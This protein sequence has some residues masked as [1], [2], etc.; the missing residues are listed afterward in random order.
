[1]PNVHTRLTQEY[2]ATPHIKANQNKS[3][4]NAYQEKLRSYPQYMAYKKEHDAIRRATPQ[5]KAY[6]KQYHKQYQNEYHEQRRST[7]QIN[8][9][10]R[11]RTVESY[12]RNVERKR[13]YNAEYRKR[14][15]QE[16]SARIV[17]WYARNVERKRAYNA[18]YRNRNVEREIA[19]SAEYRKRRSQNIEGHKTLMQAWE[20]AR[21]PS[22]SA[23][24]P[25]RSI[26]QGVALA[27]PDSTESQVEDT[28]DPWE[29]QRF[30]DAWLAKEFVYKKK[31]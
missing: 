17:G 8:Q 31:N 16:S 28:E 13:A 19:Y 5:H 29:L 10:A 14:K 30:R 15:S 20:K 3:Y 24:L 6:Q 7:P 22:D 11:A 12:A 1:M 26:L 4:H 25:P 23:V 2:E 9:E 27:S 18:E 21:A